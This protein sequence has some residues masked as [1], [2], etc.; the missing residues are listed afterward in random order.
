MMLPPPRSGFLQVDSAPCTRFITTSW[1]SSLAEVL[2]F[3]LFFFLQLLVSH[4]DYKRLL[5]QLPPAHLLCSA[6]VA[7]LAI[8]LNVP[9]AE[10]E[11]CACIRDAPVPVNLRFSRTLAGHSHTIMDLAVS[12]GQVLQTFTGHT[13]CLRCA[14]LCPDGKRAVS[15]GADNTVRIWSIDIGSE[16]QP[17]V[18]HS[19]GMCSIAV[20]LDNRTV[21][22][23]S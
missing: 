22:S 12:T 5:V 17:L 20:S 8:A 18:G 6:F 14:T 23:A 11:S 13:S 4:A 21:A 9:P 2:I 10:L 7:K 1:L 16:K 15:N 3:N 19:N